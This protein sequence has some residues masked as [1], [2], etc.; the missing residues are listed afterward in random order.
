MI[1]GKFKISIINKEESLKEKNINREKIIIDGF[2][3]LCY[4]KA[5]ESCLQRP[6]CLRLTCVSRSKEAQRPST[7]EENACISQASVLEAS[8]SLEVTQLP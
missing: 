6:L 7:S 4:S 2:V 3:V 5:V 8:K 1:M